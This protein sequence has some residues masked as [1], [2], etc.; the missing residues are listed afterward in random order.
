[1]ERLA[2]PEQRRDLRLRLARQQI[3]EILTWAGALTLVFGVV[4]YVTLPSEP[5]W[6][7]VTNLLFAP[8]FLGLAWAIHLGVIRTA[9]VPWVWASCSLLLVVLLVLVFLRQPTS[10]NLAY[11]VAV[12]TAYGP[13]TH[14]WAPFWTSAAAM[15]AVVVAGLMSTEGG[16]VVEDA[17]VCVAAILISSVLLRLRMNALGDL[18]DTQA[19]LDHQAT[20]DPMT[21][22]LNRNG[23]ERAIPAVA[24]AARRSGA[25]VLV[26]FVDVRGLKRA[27]DEHGHSFGDAVIRA[28]VDALRGC[29]RATD[30]LARWG[31]DEFVIVGEGVSGS[32]EELNVR[33]NAMLTKNAGLAGRWTEAVT[34]GFASGSGDA[35]IVELIERADAD[36]YRRRSVSPD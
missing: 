13:L 21:D 12:M 15:I 10:A 18:A 29:V 32:A 25:R 7:W 17:L 26:W 20:Y 14:A 22:V 34:V 27:N 33:V 11:I 9:A 35:D 19:R 1:M 16:V 24:G 2:S 4:N 3:P 8:I 6:S 28:T 31:G 30:V 5:V 36:M 23:L